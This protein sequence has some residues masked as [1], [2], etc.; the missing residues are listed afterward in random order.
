MNVQDLILEMFT[1]TTQLSIN[2]IV[3]RLAEVG[4]DKMTALAA[5]MALTGSGDL[6]INPRGKIYLYN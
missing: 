3:E 5:L 1:P 2:T 4:V 6:A